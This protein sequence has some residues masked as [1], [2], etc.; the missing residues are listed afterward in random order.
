MTVDAV[1]APVGCGEIV[2]EKGLVLAARSGGV[3][4][5]SVTLDPAVC[6][7]GARKGLFR[8]LLTEGVSTFALVPVPVLKLCAW[9]AAVAVDEVAVLGTFEAA[10]NCSYGGGGSLGRASMSASSLRGMAQT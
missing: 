6:S 2:L 7:S 1:D 9:L 5:A 10:S 3:A 4:A 8:A